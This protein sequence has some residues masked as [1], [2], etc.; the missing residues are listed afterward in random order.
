MMTT[1]IDTDTA[2]GGAQDSTQSTL[3]DLLLLRLNLQLHGTDLPT[4][5]P[6][7]QHP[8]HIEGCCG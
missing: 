5:A 6:H 7:P 3:G 1:S 4:P 8:S 2:F